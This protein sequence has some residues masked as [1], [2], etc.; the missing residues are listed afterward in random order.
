MHSKEFLVQLMGLNSAKLHG[1]F[2]VAVATYY[3]SETRDDIPNFF[4]DKRNR[5]NGN[6][7]YY[8]DQ[9]SLREKT[10]NSRFENTLQVGML[11]FKNNC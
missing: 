1:S 3:L 6:K 5:H 7:E 8:A 9:F 10:K 11:Y 4:T 2:I